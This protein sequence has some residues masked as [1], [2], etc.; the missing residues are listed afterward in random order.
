MIFKNPTKYCKICFKKLEIADFYQVFNGDSCLCYQCQQRL[1][2]K[3][4]KFDVDGVD[5]LAIYEYDD[6]IKSILYQ[7]K[8]CYDI[9]LAPVFLSRFKQ[10]LHLMYRGY[11]L[12]AAP[13]YELENQK[14]EFKHV[15]EMFKYINLPILYAIEKITPFKQAEHT[16]KERGHIIK[17]L[18]LVKPEEITGKKILVV[19]DVLTTG[20]T[21]KAMIEMIKTARPKCIKVLVMSKRN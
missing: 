6:N 3:F 1:K 13:S 18:Q 21:I 17:H 8:G 14:R 20:S 11:T 15:E 9:E 2:P 7:F 12:V 16:K 4:I 5:A 19:D 10:E